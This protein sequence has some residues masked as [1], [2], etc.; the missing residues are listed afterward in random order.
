MKWFTFFSYRTYLYRSIA[1]LILGIV[2][3]FVP[4]D[5]IQ[6]LVV[7][8]GIF[9]LL[10]GLGTAYAAHKAEH[11]FLISLGGIASVV[12]IVL[13]IFL[14]VRPSFFVELVMTLFGVLLMF[15]GLLQIINV[16]SVRTQLNQSRF[17]IVGGVIPLTVGVVFLIFPETV[18]DILGILLGITL[19]L[20]A[21]NELSLGYRIRSYFKKDEAKVEDIPFEEVED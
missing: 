10:A 19:I 11:N 18:K 5:T 16:A 13:G 21:I 7:I 15:V 6:T 2:A 1:A 20:Y 17:Y 12:S 8:I 4:N 9:V 14:I 3:L